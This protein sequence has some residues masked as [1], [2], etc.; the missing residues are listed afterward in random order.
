MRF[1]V[2]IAPEAMR[3]LRELR[4]HDRR[5]IL[6]V[7][8]RVLSSNPTQLTKSR[9]KR[10]RGVDS[11]QY[12]LRVD[13]YRVLYDVASEQVQILRILSKP[14]VAVYLREMGHEPEDD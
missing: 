12:R 7:A 3:D 2:L 11:P 13:D 9:I 6:D 8:E 1:A 10:L 4:A 5:K 14:R